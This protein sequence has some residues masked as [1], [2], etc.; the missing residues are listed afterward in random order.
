VV[1]GCEFEREGSIVLWSHGKVSS[2]SCGGC[3]SGMFCEF[4]ADY[5]PHAS[6]KIGRSI[7]FIEEPAASDRACGEHCV[8]RMCRFGEEDSVEQ[9]TGKIRGAAEY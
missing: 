7:D 2:S 4:P 8:R 6:R 5:I 1:A 3:S 9:K